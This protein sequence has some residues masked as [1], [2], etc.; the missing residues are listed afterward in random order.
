MAG[1]KLYSE[2]KNLLAVEVGVLPWVHLLVTTP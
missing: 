1:G 2:E